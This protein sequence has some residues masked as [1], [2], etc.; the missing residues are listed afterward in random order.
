MKALVKRVIVCP[1][2]QIRIEWNF[3]DVIS[4]FDNELNLKM[5]SLMTIT[6]ELKSHT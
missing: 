1:D 3:S 5:L 6:R 4:F 2:K